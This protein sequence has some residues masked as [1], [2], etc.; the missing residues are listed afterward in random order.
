[1]RQSRRGMLEL[2]VQYDEHAYLGGGY[3]IPKRGA[4]QTQAKKRGTCTTTHVESPTE[5]T[6]RAGYRAH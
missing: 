6:G 4:C 2:S 1:M 3:G 5:L